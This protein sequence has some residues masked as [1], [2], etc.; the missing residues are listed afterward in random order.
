MAIAL[1]VIIAGS[2]R[3]AVDIFGM[4]EARRRY[5]VA[6]IVGLAAIMSR[7]VQLEFTWGDIEA[8]IVTGLL[9]AAILEAVEASRIWFGAFN[10]RP[11]DE[12]VQDGHY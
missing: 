6:A 7:A 11:I 1:W 4:V 12:S 9:M 5:A 8:G 3:H 2:S 10:E